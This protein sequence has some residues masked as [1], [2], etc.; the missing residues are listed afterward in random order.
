MAEWFKAP[1]LKT[2]RGRNVPRGFESHPFRQNT[3]YEKERRRLEDEIGLSEIE[4]KQERIGNRQVN[5]EQRILSARP[6]KRSDITLKFAIHDEQ[7]DGS[8]YCP[9]ALLRDLRRLLDKPDVF[10]A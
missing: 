9:P 5:I 2:G 10:A 1:V 3:S 8:S 4:K 6:A 7:Y